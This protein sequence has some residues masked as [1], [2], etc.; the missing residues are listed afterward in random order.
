MSAQELL[1]AYKDQHMVERNFGFLK[2]PVFVNA[3][4][5]KFPVGSRPSDWSSSSLS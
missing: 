2:D 3:L 1:V 5:L 4:F